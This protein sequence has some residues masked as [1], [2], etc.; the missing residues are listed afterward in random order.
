MRALV[1][2]DN[3]N[4]LNAIK[5]SLELRG[6]D[7]TSINYLNSKDIPKDRF[8]LAIVDGL[9]GDGVRVL[10]NVNA[11]RKFLYTGSFVIEK[12]VREAGLEVHPKGKSLKEILEVKK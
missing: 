7:V 12:V 10:G 2:E 6:Y 8:D 11:G 1:V 4:V 3:L 9:D 5:N